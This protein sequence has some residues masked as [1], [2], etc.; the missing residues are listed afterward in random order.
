LDAV[1]KVKAVT[2]ILILDKKGGEGVVREFADL[3]L[4][5]YA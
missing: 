4:E 1:R 3:I 5:Q 2:G